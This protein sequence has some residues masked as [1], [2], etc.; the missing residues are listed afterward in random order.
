MRQDRSKEHVG[1]YLLGTSDMHV[2]QDLVVPFGKIVAFIAVVDLHK[3]IIPVHGWKRY[4]YLV[5]GVL[6]RTY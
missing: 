4:W 2:P 6:V 1:E 5:F 3:R